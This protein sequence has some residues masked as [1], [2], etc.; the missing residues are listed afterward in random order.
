MSKHLVDFVFV[1]KQKDR[2]GF[3]RQ[4]GDKCSSLFSKQSPGI[5]EHSAKT[6]RQSVGVECTTHVLH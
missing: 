2:R 3:E 1:E 6:R 4:S 5:D